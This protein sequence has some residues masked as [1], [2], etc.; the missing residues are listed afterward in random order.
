MKSWLQDN[1]IEMNS[2]HNGNV[3]A[4]RLIMSSKNKIYMYK[5]SITNNG[6]IDI[7]KFYDAVNEYNKTNKTF[8]MKPTDVKISAS[9]G[10]EVE[11]NDKYPKFKV[12]DHVRISKNKKIS[13][14]G[15]TPKWS[16]EGFA[17]KKDKNT[18][19]WTDVI[20]DLKKW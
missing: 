10:I 4:A 5:T 11:S 2:T 7:D 14:K 16:E 18:I 20:S 6:Y 3:A 15:Y 9:I 17:I 19:L 1:G 13:A 12:G 8:K